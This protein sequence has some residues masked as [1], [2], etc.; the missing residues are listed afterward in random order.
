VATRA[1]QRKLDL[2]R[3]LAVFLRHER[4]EREWSQATASEKASL[5]PRHWRK[6]EAEEVNFTAETLE[7]ICAAF[8]VDVQKVFAQK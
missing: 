8:D 5:N 3:R 6:L 4:R 7:R 2:R 1:Q